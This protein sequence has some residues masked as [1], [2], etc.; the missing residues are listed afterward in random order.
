MP[1]TGTIETRLVAIGELNP[2]PYN[3]RVD[4]QPGDPE[5]V[6]IER[7]IDEFGLVVPMV[8]NSRTG[9]LI[10][11][12]QRLKILKARGDANV[13]VVVVDVNED[14]EKL[15][16]LALNRVSG[17][18]EYD[19]LA[20]LLSEMTQKQALN[21]SATG[22]DQDAISQILA[23]IPSGDFEIPGGEP[24]D[25]PA[26]GIAGDGEALTTR[27]IIIFADKESR[28]EFVEKCGIAVDTAADKVTLHWSTIR[29]A[30]LQ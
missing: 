28:K 10:S 5:Y 6:D 29:D 25:L 26:T 16:N 30:V 27:V 11:G 20:D 4:L 3:P 1:K 17:R 7:S 23:T 9:N 18:W 15:M 24:G 12:H 2:A 8:W 19:Q 22:F 14:Q 13:P 21:I